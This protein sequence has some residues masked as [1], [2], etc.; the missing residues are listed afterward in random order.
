MGA[1]LLEH[2]LLQV[3]QNLVHLMHLKQNYQTTMILTSHYM[4]EASYLCDR[5]II[6]DSGKVLA[7]GTL[8]ELL[9]EYM[10]GEIIE[11]SV[12]GN[13]TVEDLP[14]QSKLKSKELD[15]NGRWILVVDDLINF[16]PSLQK[17]IENKGYQMTYLECRKMTLDDLFISMTGRHLSH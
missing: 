9:S 5:I 7:R 12:N 13:F 4:E 6:M 2:W 10:A 11:F 1:F 15:Q 8:E 3:M 16:L 17:A 14:N